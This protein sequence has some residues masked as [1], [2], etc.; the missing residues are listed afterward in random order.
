M[1]QIWKDIGESEL[2]KD[3]MLLELEKECLEVYRRKVDEAANAKA[4]LHQ[5]V[6]AKEAEL[7]SLMAALGELN[8]RTPVKFSSTYVNHPFDEPFNDLS[9]FIY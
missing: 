8:L 5:S 7:A 9:D 6:A 1:Q 2:E 4:R 3:R